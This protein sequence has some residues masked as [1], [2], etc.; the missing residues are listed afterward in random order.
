MLL[1]LGKNYPKIAKMFNVGVNAIVSI[2]NG[3]TWKHV[4]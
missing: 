4:G 3:E 2:K 1:K